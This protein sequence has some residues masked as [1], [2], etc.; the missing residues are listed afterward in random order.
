M[1][2]I[3]AGTTSGTALVN[4]GDTTGTLVLQTNGTTTAVTI[5]TNQVVTLA[6]PLP[7][8]SGG[9]GGTA[10]P[11]AG[12]IVYGTGTVQAVSAAGTTGQYLKSN[13]ASAPSWITAS[14]S[15]LT[16]L[17]TVTA[18]NSA[19]VDID[20]TFSSTYDSYVI[21]FSNMSPDTDTVTP[22]VRLKVSGAYQ[23][24]G[25]NYHSAYPSNASASYT[26]QG[27]SSQAFIALMGGITQ[28][29]R[30]T[31][32]YSTADMH[33][34]INQPSNS[35]PTKSI[36]WNGSC[37]G[38]TYNVLF[39]SGQNDTYLGAGVLTGVRFYYSS[40]NVA[41]GTF[42]LYGYSNT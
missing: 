25:Y 14:A 36:S 9:T 40:G 30:S 38:S 26:A 32:P 27:A 1:S 16:L 39:G 21:V 8:A 42:R 31:Q 35:V 6:Q 24:S 10:T 5:G 7:V 37:A 33:V 41:T 22:R 34:R 29:S 12:G 23:T 28:D 17:S 4:T 11:T 3:A 19:T 20:T 2:T 15:G 18:S 13:G